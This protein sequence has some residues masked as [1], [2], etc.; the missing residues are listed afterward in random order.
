[1]PTYKKVKKEDLGNYNLSAWED[2]GAEYLECDDWHIQDNQGIRPSQHGFVKSRSW[3]TNLISFY[4]GVT[5]L[6]D[7]GKAA[8]VFYLD[9]ARA[10]DTFL[11]ALSWRNWQPV[12]WTG[13]LFTG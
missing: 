11:I 1:M 6:V 7:E 8:D 9:F 4:D 2:Y 12:A 10:F 13:A 3:L 5:F